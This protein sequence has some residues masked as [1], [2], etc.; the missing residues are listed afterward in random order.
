MRQSSGTSTTNTLNLSP[1]AY[2]ALRLKKHSF[3]MEEELSLDIVRLALQKVNLQLGV[4][5][6]FF[7]IIFGK[8]PMFST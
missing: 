1:P 3:R 7:S 5:L 4:C 8:L 6:C 2:R